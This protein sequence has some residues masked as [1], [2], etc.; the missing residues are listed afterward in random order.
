MLRS[1]IILEK[2]DSK[3]EKALEDDDFKKIFGSLE[4]EG[5]VIFFDAFPTS[6]PT[7]KVDVMTPHY[8]HYYS[9]GKAPTDTENP[10]PINFLTVENTEFEFFIASKEE[11]KNLKIKDKSIIDWFK[12]ALVNYGIGAKTSVG[13][14]YFYE[15]NGN[16][17]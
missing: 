11:L 15:N 6:K 17:D 14:G 10:V 8:K 9:E 5:E 1:Y 7:I 3:E 12:E 13:Y 4:Q 2:F 16:A